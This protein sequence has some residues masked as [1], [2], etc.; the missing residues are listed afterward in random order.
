MIRQGMLRK[1]VAGGT[2]ALTLFTLNG[3]NSLMILDR[4]PCRPLDETRNGLN[5]GEGSGFVVLES[6]DQLMKTGKKALAE[7]T[8]YGNACDAFHQ[9]ASSPEGYGAWLSMRT[10]LASARLVP[11][12][13]GYINAHGTGTRNNDLSEGI[14]VQ[15]IF[16]DGVPDISSTKA[17]TG[18]TLGA[19]GAIEAVISVISLNRQCIFPNLRFRQQMN[20]LNFSP[21]ITLKQGVKMNHIMS[22]SFGFGGNNTTLIISR[23]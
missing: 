17:Y 11:A 22:N 16:T 15:K 19:A 13:I 23:C 12:D 2:D 4:G 9:T 21:V 1:V 20:E 7:V 10:A 18:H 14:A 5:L 8:G 6:E 3:F